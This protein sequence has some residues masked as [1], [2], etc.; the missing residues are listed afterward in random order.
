MIG[1]SLLIPFLSYLL[2]SEISG[3][4]ATETYNYSNQ[5]QEDSLAN[6]PGDTQYYFGSSLTIFQLFVNQGVFSILGAHSNT[7]ASGTSV[8]FMGSTYFENSGKFSLAGLDNLS[9][10][11]FSGGLFINSGQFYV[12]QS[13]GF[14]ISPLSFENTG[15][16]EIVTNGQDSQIILGKP[17]SNTGIMIFNN[18]SMTQPN[19]SGV[20][21]ILLCNGATFRITGNPTSQTLRI[22]DSSVIHFPEILT[23]V[24]IVLEAFTAGNILRF[25]LPAEQEAMK[26]DLNSLTQA[27]SQD[28][29]VLTITYPLGGE[30][31]INIGTGYLSTAIQGVFTNQYFEVSTLQTNVNPFV[32]VVPEMDPITVLAVAS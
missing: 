23:T 18:T 9:F 19:M 1:I 10:F 8:S 25:D 4:A 32:C 30:Y 22:L 13:N 5:I 28:L 26:R 16:M 21:C 6:Q 20:G 29:G 7:G 31:H 15:V 24:P 12:Q 3:V 11:S 14:V 27:Y 2:V 17:G